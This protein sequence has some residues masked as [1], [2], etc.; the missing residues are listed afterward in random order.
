MSDASRFTYP[1][2]PPPAER[3]RTIRFSVHHENIFTVVSLF[4]G[5]DNHAIVRTMD[6]AKGILHVWYCVDAELPV[7]RLLEWMAGRFP[8]VVLQ[9]SPGMLGIDGDGG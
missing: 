7:K 2:A 3:W 8:L 4:E 1:P 6:P 5:Y 9:E